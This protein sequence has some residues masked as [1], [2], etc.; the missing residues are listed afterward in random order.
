MEINIGSID[1]LV[2]SIPG[3]AIGAAG[4]SI[5]SWFGLIAPVPLGTAALG[6]CPF[7]APFE[8][9]TCELRSERSSA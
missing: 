4:L 1:R 7:A 3:R 2:R 9:S 5:T 6:W 8:P